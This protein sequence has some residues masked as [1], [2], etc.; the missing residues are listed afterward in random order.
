[1]NE[2]A[3]PDTHV[4]DA[5]GRIQHALHDQLMKAYREGVHEGVALAIINME[6]HATVHSDRGERSAAVALRACINTLRSV[7]G[8]P[9]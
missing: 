1:M 5:I 2:A 3:P 4:P 9:S 8:I 6:H 7:V